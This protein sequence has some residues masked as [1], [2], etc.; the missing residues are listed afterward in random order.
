VR[1]EALA[2]LSTMPADLF[3][4]RWDLEVL[5]DCLVRASVFIR[6]VFD[7][8][9][10]GIS[11]LEVDVVPPELYAVGP[12]GFEYRLLNEDCVGGRYFGLASEF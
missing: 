5:P 10:S 12:D 1:A 4:N 9:C 2:V 6:R 11:I 8:K 3:F 7:W